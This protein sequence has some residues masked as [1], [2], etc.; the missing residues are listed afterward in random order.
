MS[1]DLR[2]CAVAFLL[3]VGWP[4]AAQTSARPD[5][6]MWTRVSPFWTSLPDCLTTINLHNNHTEEPLT[7]YPVLYL[8][9]GT[10]LRLGPVEMKPLD[11]AAIKVN[12]TVRALGYPDPE[13]GGAEFRYFSEH[14]GR[15]GV[16]TSVSMP[17][18]NLLY[19]VESF[20]GFEPKSNAQFSAFWL[21][22]EQTEVFYAVHNVS[23]TPLV[24]TPKLRLWDRTFDLEPVKIHAKGFTK[25]RLTTAQVAEYAKRIG[26]P[27]AGA[28]GGI[29]LEHDGPA[30]ALY[31]TGW[32]DDAGAGYSNMMSFADPAAGVGSKLFGVQLFLGKQP[33][34]VEPG[35][36]LDLETHVV[37]R[38]ISSGSVMANATAHFKRGAG[39]EAVTL[40]PLRLDAGAVGEYD[41]NQLQM[42]GKIPR[43][44][45]EILL[46]VDSFAAPGAL[47]GR[48]Y[49]IS[50]DRSYGLYS[51]LES[52]G[53]GAF[54][55]VHWSLQ[56]DDNTIIT[57]ANT[58]DQAKPAV[59]E[60]AHTGGSMVL[61]PIEIMPRESRTINLRRDLERLLPDRSRISGAGLSGGYRVV[62]P[63]DPLHAELVVK[64]HVLSLS[65]RTAAPFY[66][67]CAYATSLYLQ[68]GE[69]STLGV[70]VGQGHDVQPRCNMSTGGSA[71]EY[72]AILQPD[73]GNQISIGPQYG[74]TRTI[75]GVNAGSRSMLFSADVPTQSNP[76]GSSILA[77]FAPLAQVAVAPGITCGPPVTRGQSATV[78]VSNLGSAAIK[79]DFLVGGQVKVTKNGG[80]SWS[81]VM[82][83]SGT[84]RATITPPNGSPFVKE[85]TITVN[86]RNWHTNTPSATQVSNGTINTLPVPPALGADS[87]LGYHGIDVGFTVTYQ[88]VSGGP[89]DGYA[90]FQNQPVT[91]LW[92]RYIINP[93]LENSGSTF[94]QRQWGACGIISHANLLTQT[95]R[96]EYNHLSQ[97]HHAKF[98]SL[99][100][101]S[102]YNPGDFVEPRISPP[103]S[104]FLTFE[105]GTAS[106]MQ[107]QL[108]QLQAL[109]EAFEPYPVNYS[110]SGTP[111]GNI[112]YAPYTS[113]P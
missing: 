60:L 62:S 112:N 101:N 57:I 79:W 59:V 26:R 18:N 19:S 97:S 68:G 93:D 98:D 27:V 56:G 39:V 47:I 108:N 7:V 95:R 5:L 83:T 48:A 45:S 40:P 9:D 74:Y 84:V 30:S 50:A 51:V 22:T 81:G 100:S 3:V 88:A 113:C 1:Q 71:G 90:F 21:P 91:S 105:Q 104:N 65:R 102:A 72:G 12:E 89:D 94:S 11:S 14:G 80:S 44:V 70:F 46:E 53:T 23:A 38:N 54:S 76:C 31:A 37:I 52:Q 64:T 13:F 4:L 55:G 92:S 96:H 58:G 20:T 10:P 49:S 77:G 82:V 17:A 78:N 35:R 73:G 28:I 15:L 25:L 33:G 32:L 8:T 107:A 111:L 85:C 86:N 110:A 63:D 66:G 29:T 69:F 67:S 16:E 34:L 103:G 99:L 43:G 75:T 87:G 6:P 36:P 109:Y 41:L 2:W 42:D 61:M 24:L 106:A